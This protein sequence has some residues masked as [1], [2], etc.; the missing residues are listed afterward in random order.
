MIV[1]NVAARADDD[2]NHVSWAQHKNDRRVTE[3][4]NEI[5]REYR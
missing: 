3:D 4:E 1:A 2:Y 5:G